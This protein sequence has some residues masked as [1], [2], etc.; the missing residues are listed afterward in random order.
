VVPGMSPQRYDVAT[1]AKGDLVTT[2]PRKAA[3]GTAVAIGAD[4][5]TVEH[6]LVH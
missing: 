5:C 4:R 6:G 1:V 3:R 2:E